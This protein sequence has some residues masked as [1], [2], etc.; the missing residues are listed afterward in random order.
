MLCCDL[1]AVCIKQMTA[2]L[3]RSLQKNTD[4]IT[5]TSFVLA[6]LAQD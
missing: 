2:N 5:V 6:F 3:D 1:T 4:T